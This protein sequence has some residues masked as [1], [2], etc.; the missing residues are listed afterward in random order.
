MVGDA[1]VEI[2]RY[3]ALTPEEQAA[4]ERMVVE[5]LR[6][7]EDA[8]AAAQGPRPAPAE[9]DREARGRRR[10]RSPQRPKS[11]TKPG[12]RQDERRFREEGSAG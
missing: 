3:Y 1:L 7:A 10:A 5:S 2:D 9:K 6:R 8:R 12:R 4:V 11:K